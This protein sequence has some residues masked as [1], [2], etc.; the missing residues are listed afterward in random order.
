MSKLAFVGAIRPVAMR[1]PSHDQVEL[2]FNPS[3]MLHHGVRLAVKD[4]WTWGQFIA[5]RCP[6]CSC[7]PE[8]P[9]TVTLEGGKGQAACAPAG[10]YGFPTCTGCTL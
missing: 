10:A 6:S 2:S 4:A 5:R 1:S 7:T 3:P 8:E 9:C